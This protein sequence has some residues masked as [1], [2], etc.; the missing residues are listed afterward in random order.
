[1]STG[2]VTAVAVVHTFLPNAHRPVGTTAID[3]RAV[4]G[5]VRLDVDGL[6]GDTQCDR[7]HHGGTY[8]AVY[9]YADEDAAWWSRELGRPIPPGLFGENLRTSGVDVSGAE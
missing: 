8:Q 5:P 1:M 3:K 7:R 9:A 2:V 4:D 6:A